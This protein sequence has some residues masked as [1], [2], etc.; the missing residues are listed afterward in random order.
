LDSIEIH[1]SIKFEFQCPEGTVFDETLSVC[2]WP[3]ASAPCEEITT[4]EAETDSPEV[5]GSGDADGDSTENSIIVSP[6]FDFEC[7][8]EGLFP[9][10]NNC[11]KF[12]LCK[13]SDDNVEP[14][15]LY[16]C[17]DGYLFDESILRCQKEDGVECDKVTN[18]AQEQFEIA[19]TLQESEL[20]SFFRTWSFNP[21]IIKT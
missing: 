20:D 19:I 16:R 3:W 5:D 1:T 2:N 6:T 4:V 8:N 17:P 9:H 11:Q 14:A 10:E 18:R 15:E 7:S 21:K 12:W 13:G